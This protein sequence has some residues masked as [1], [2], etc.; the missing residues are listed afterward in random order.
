MSAPPVRTSVSSP[1]RPLAAADLGSANLDA[2]AE[3]HARCFPHD[4]WSRRALAEVL[5]MPGAG[6]WLAWDDPGPA[7]G[8][9]L[10]RTAAD[11]A[12]ILTFGVAPERRRQGIGSQLLQVA[13]VAL[14]ARA[15]ARLF[16]E[17]AVD[18]DSAR[19][20]YQRLGFAEV[21][22]RSAYLSTPAG[23]RDALVLARRPGA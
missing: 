13:L 8:F 18:N 3:L 15:V 1:V 16:L 7:V 21:G 9:L 11:E 17:V 4:P 23:P 10:V 22:R 12:E 19:R 14:E 5:A 6:G 2:L 20:L